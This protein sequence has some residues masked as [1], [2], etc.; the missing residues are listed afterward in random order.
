MTPMFYEKGGGNREGSNTIMPNTNYQG[1]QILCWVG[2]DGNNIT[3][4]QTLYTIF[5]IVL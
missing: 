3:Y 5:S 4:N 1:I 2:W